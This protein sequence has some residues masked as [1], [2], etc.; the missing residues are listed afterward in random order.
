MNLKLQHPP[1]TIAFKYYT[2]PLHLWSNA[3]P[4]NIF[5]LTKWWEIKDMVH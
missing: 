3:L 2:Q 5:F 1:P 4:E